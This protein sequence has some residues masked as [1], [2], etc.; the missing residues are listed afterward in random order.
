MAKRRRLKKLGTARGAQAKARARA[1]RN[2]ESNPKSIDLSGL[3]EIGELAIPA[4]AGYAGARLISRI[5]YV[6]SQKKWPRAARH[7]AVGA[8]L[9]TALGAYLVLP[10]IRRFSNYQVSATLGAAIA[11]AQSI[12]QTYLPKFGWM[13]SDYTA[14]A[15]ASSPKPVA[16]MPVATLSPEEMALLTDDDLDAGGADPA[17]VDPKGAVFDAAGAI[18]DGDLDDLGLDMN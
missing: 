12:I 15:P 16:T 18:D 5:T 13:V 4:F 2:P 14:L 3:Y 6:Q 17:D 10:R 8:S 7:L 9:A 1:R 11:S